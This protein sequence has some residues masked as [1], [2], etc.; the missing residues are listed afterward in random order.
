MAIELPREARQQAVASIER[1]CRDELD[2]PVGNIA[3]AA[4]LNYLLEEIGPLIY[5]QAIAEAQER[6]L[7]RVQ[8]LDIDLHEDEWRYWPK[9]DAARAKGR[10]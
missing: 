10:R 9:L 8:E 2:H 3:A 1:Y 7:Q 5:N 6:L 4:L